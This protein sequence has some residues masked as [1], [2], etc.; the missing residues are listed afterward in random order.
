MLLKKTTIESHKLKEM[1][2]EL[3]A[4]G[5]EDS[6]SSLAVKNLRF[7]IFY[8]SN[9]GTSNSGNHYCIGL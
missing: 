1:K 5:G 4:L 7:S 3:Q 2:K 8:I 9:S 6:D